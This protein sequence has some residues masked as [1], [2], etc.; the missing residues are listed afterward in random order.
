MLVKRTHLPSRAVSA[1]PPERM[2]SR[3]HRRS[4]R[5][6]GVRILQPRLRGTPRPEAF[7]G[8]VVGWLFALSMLVVAALLASELAP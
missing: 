6:R 1:A 5:H 4:A 2:L 3:S 8:R 7:W